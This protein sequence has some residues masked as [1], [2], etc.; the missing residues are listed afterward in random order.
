MVSIIHAKTYSYS[1]IFLT[2][3][4]LISGCGDSDEDST[5]SK[6]TID[7]RSTISFSD[8]RADFDTKLLQVANNTPEFNL[9]VGLS[10]YEVGSFLQDGALHGSLDIADQQLTLNSFEEISYRFELDEKDASYKD[11]DTSLKVIP[12]FSFTLGAGSNN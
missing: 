2:Q 5:A 9:R 4:F 10:A 7:P 1:A 3:L 11:A 12:G 6:P 8:A